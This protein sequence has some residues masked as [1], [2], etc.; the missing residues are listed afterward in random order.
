MKIDFKIQGP[1]FKLVLSFELAPRYL[2]WV[3][4]GV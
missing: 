3:D 2:V 4:Y 1:A